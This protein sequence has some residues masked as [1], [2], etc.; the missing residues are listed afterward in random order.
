[1]NKLCLLLQRIATLRRLLGKQQKP[2]AESLPVNLISLDDAGERAVTSGT[3]AGGRR[4]SDASSG[5]EDGTSSQLSRSVVDDAENCDNICVSVDLV[6]Q[7]P[8][9]C[10]T[11]TCT[12]VP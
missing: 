9:T 5:F 8:N 11:A 1:M 3:G 2:D 4:G 12:H 7:K 6:C 10:A